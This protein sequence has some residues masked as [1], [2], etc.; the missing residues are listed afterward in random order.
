[1]RATNSGLAHGTSGSPQASLEQE[2]YEQTVRQNETSLQQ[3]TQHGELVDPS[4]VTEMEKHGYK[5]HKEELIFTTRDATGQIVWLERGNKYA[6]YEHLKTRGHLQHLAHYFHVEEAIIPRILRDVIH[7]GKVISNKIV[8][9]NGRKAY[10]RCYE[11]R[12]RKVILAGIGSNGFLVTAY[13][14]S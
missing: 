12:N 14:K 6:G 5:F 3:L 10:E 1:M 7:S 9:R 13:P 4:L 11:Y 2:I 8:E